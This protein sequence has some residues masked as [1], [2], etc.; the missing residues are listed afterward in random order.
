[1]TNGSRKCNPKKRFKVGLST[2]NPPHNQL[3]ISSPTNGMALNKLVITVAP[4]KLIWPHGN[5]YPIKAVA[6]I[7]KKIVTPEAHNT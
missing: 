3:A 6:I 4:Q 5:T 2:E 1:M 7:S